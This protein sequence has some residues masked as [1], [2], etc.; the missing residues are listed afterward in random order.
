M[1]T[2]AEER[3]CTRCD[4]SNLGDDGPYAGG[5]ENEQSQALVSAGVDKDKFSTLTDDGL[6]DEDGGDQAVLLERRG[7][8]RKI[9]QCS[10]AVQGVDIGRQCEATME[11]T[12]QG[13]ANERVEDT[14][15]TDEARTRGKAT[16]SSID[17]IPSQ[18]P[19]RPS[20]RGERLVQPG[21]P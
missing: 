1:R 7:G 2:D 12:G 14:R 18:L 19:Q 6:G 11:K 9:V 10:R 5:W 4:I 15:Q 16:T 8:E 21:A 20:H 13:E 17:R 3:R